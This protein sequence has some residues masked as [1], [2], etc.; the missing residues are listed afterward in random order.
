MKITFKIYSPILKKIFIN[1][2]T[3]RTMEDFRLY[4]YSLYSGNWEIV[5]VEE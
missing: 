2:E 1:V 3:F 5:S 4:A